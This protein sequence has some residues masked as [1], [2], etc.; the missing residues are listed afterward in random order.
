MRTP[1]LPAIYGLHHNAWRC[2]DAERSRRFY[3][4]L[5][6]LPLTD[7]FEIRQSKTGRDVQALHLFFA[8]GDGSSLAFF[9]V[10]GMPFDFKVQ[11]DFDLHIALAVDADAL[12]PMIDRARAAGVEVRG[13]SHHGRIRSIYLRDPDGYVV[14]LA[15]PADE[16]ATLVPTA[17][18][19]KTLDAWQQRK[20]EPCPLQT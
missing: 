2:S 17:E 16:G 10:P 1:T 5:L 11:H 15:A 8:L 4:D 18:A 7:A 9:D 19:R 3:E 12:Q 14:E 20:S 13:I 6:G